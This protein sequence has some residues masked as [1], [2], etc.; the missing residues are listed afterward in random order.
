MESPVGVAN[1]G[2][3]IHTALAGWYVSNPADRID[4]R[5]G[6]ET[7]IRDDWNKFS[8]AFPDTAG[9]Q[10]T[11]YVS[12]SDLVR[13]MV[14]G[15]VQWLGDSGADSILEIESSER[16]IAADV[17]DGMKDGNWVVLYD[18]IVL[19]GK[20]DAIVFDHRQ[21]AR[22]FIDHKS[23]ADFEQMTYRMYV[24][25]QLLH[26]M[27]LLDDSSDP[28]IHGTTLNMLRRVKRSARSKP[29]Y[30]RR[31]YNPYNHSQLRN[32]WERT[33]RLIQEI[34]N[35]EYEFPGKKLDFYTNELPMN[36]TNDCKWKCPF[37][38]ICDM[39]DD[40][41]DWESA[42]KMTTMVTDPNARYK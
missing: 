8:D 2:T 4:P 22:S 1:I 7:A 25:P 20:V 15:Y 24:R 37:T 21:N 28:V 36:P 33:Q 18:R 39:M 9:L 5:D 12:Q 13:A 23:G 14:E 41:S 32:Y 40:G 38:G 17:T 34:I 10:Q 42:L 19:I 31:D 11:Q 29:P 27:L 6:I 26:Y 35:I 16:Y 30:Y 3:Q